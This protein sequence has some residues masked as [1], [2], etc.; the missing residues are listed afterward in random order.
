MECSVRE[1]EATEKAVERWAAG[2]EGTTK[3]VRIVVQ[4]KQEE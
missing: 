3:V 1:A 2:E 4:H